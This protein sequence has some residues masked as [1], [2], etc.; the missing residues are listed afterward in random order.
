[1]VSLAEKKLLDAR[2]QREA[3]RLVESV[4]SPQLRP[5]QVLYQ[6]TEFKHGFPV[7]QMLEDV[8]KA[9]VDN[10][11][12]LELIRRTIGGYELNFRF[13]EF[14]GDGL[15][16][17]ASA[18]E[19]DDNEQEHIDFCLPVEQEPLED[20]YWTRLSG[21]ETSFA[22]KVL[23]WNITKESGF[24]APVIP[25]F[26]G[27]V[28]DVFVDHSALSGRPGHGKLTKGAQVEFK[29]D[30][31]DDGKICAKNVRLVEKNEAQE[32]NAAYRR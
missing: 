11:L 25:D 26:A 7:P 18:I 23:L 10:L 21:S 14:L 8:E 3:C 24:I 20:L 22:G 19:D 1:V 16:L 15:L 13:G 2:L 32:Q 4:G 29:M 9:T 28:G 12:G 6:M 30:V 5:I 31:R 17:W 27:L